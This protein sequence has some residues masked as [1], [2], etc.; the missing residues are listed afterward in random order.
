[1]VSFA[2]ASPRMEILPEEEQ[3]RALTLYEEELLYLI[4]YGLEEDGA[5]VEGE[6]MD[7]V[8]FLKAFDAQARKRK[9]E[10]FQIR[11]VE[12]VKATREKI[13]SPLDQ[14]RMHVFSQLDIVVII[15]HHL[16]YVE[17]INRLLRTNQ[18]LSTCGE[19][20][21]A[22]KTLW[23]TRDMNLLSIFFLLAPFSPE[24]EHKIRIDA[25]DSK[26]EKKVDF[27]GLRI[28]H[29]SIERYVDS[30]SISRCIKKIT[31]LVRKS[32]LISLLIAKYDLSAVRWKIK[33]IID[34]YNYMNY[35]ERMNTGGTGLEQWL[36]DKTTCFSYADI[37]HIFR[38][39]ETVIKVCDER[40]GSVKS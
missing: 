10:E 31:L 9:L 1:M 20:L 12:E 37:F 24:K 3:H 16:R 29:D 27:S 36:Q 2:R 34:D 22:N 21:W 13:L 33:F 8:E 39:K 38:A 32:S 30:R 6:E 17:D 26:Y 40:F 4:D 7:D 19:H 28:V 11:R 25:K 15:A 5:G 14:L 23:E 18:F 35:V